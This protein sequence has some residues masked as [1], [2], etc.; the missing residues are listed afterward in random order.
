[1]PLRMRR[2]STR[3]MPRGLF[4]SIGL[5][6]LHSPVATAQQIEFVQLALQLP[7]QTSRFTARHNGRTSP[8]RIF[9][10]CGQ[11]ASGRGKQ[12]TKRDKDTCG[13]QIFCLIALVLIGSIAGGLTLVA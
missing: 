9:C 11:L 4:G 7:M 8:M 5:M 12:T 2:S 1:M 10:R 13:S 6:T 3:G